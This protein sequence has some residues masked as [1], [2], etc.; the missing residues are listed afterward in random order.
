MMA[1]MCVSVVFILIDILSVTK[2]LSLQMANGINPFWKLAF[3]FKCLTDT[4]ILDDFKTALDKLSQYKLDQIRDLSGASGHHGTATRDQWMELS[5]G[6]SGAVAQ[7]GQSDV[8]PL[9]GIRVEVETQVERVEG[10]RATQRS[11]EST[12]EILVGKG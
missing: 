2:V 10:G 7:A 12:S 1:S 5:R 6:R 3:V 8:V 9:D 4:I 11:S